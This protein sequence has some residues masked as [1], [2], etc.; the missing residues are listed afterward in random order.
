MAAVCWSSEWIY[1]NKIYN[2]NI[3]TF[4]GIKK[5]A[6]QTIVIDAGHGG[7]DS[8]KIGVDNV[9]E[10]D[11]NLQVAKKVQK[12]LLDQN[13]KVVMT[14]E[15]D[16]DLADSKI[17]DLRKRVEIINVT[18]PDLAV[19]IHQNSY[20]SESIQG[21][22]VF[23]YSQSQQGEKLAAILQQELK[24]VDPENHRQEK[25]NDSYFILKKTE[26]PVVIVECGFLSNQKETEK[27]ISD[28][29]QDLLAKAI[30]DGIIE[31][32]SL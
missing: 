31:F 16:C 26:V 3:E 9:L 12:L 11:I 19:S 29:Y 32:L 7:A 18:K 8:G 22:Q 17:E 21:A 1:Q 4:S 20:P 24:K 15:Q 25:G 13:I 23:Y 6:N 2:E 5:G 30:F 10:K 14:R 27:L 28:E